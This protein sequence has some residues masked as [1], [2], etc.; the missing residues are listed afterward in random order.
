MTKESLYDQV[1]QINYVYPAFWYD[2]PLTER[3]RARRH[4][5]WL[6]DGALTYRLAPRSAWISP[7]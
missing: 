6:V 3:Y 5:L 2:A 4:V 1:H 7:A